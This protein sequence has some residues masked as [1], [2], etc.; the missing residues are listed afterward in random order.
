M[1]AATD[2]ILSTHIASCILGSQT[3]YRY[4]ALDLSLTLLLLPFQ[5]WDVELYDEELN[6]P[7]KCN[8][9]DL[10]EELG[11]VEYLFSDKTGT[12]TEN[13]MEFKGRTR[14]EEKTSDAEAYGAHSSWLLFWSE[15]L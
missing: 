5:V 8:S 3:A 2:A 9:S 12:L 6:Q 7:A 13:V 14:T 4:T 11:Q 10:N 15:I 1:E